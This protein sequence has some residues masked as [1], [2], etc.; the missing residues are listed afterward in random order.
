MPYADNIDIIGSSENGIKR[1]ILALKA[2]K[3][4]LKINEKPSTE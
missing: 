3:M 4:G 1:T 2:V